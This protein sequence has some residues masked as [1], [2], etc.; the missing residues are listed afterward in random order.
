[1]IRAHHGWRHVFVTA[2]LT[3]AAALLV[4]ATTR[5]EADYELWLAR[6][7]F[8]SMPAVLAFVATGMAAAWRERNESLRACAAQVLPGLLYSAA[9]TALLFALLPPELRIQFDET[10]I[11]GASKSMHEHH[12]CVVTTGALP[13]EGE[14]FARENTT[15][16]RPPLFA[17]LV[18]LLHRVT[19]FRIE[20]GFWVNGILLTVG[21]TATFR[22]VAARAGRLCAFLAPACI[23]TVPAIA[24]SATS[25][26]FDLMASAWL[27]IALFAAITFLERPTNG[28]F[29]W[30]LAALM[31]LAQSRYES[32]LASG[33]IAAFVFVAVRKR[34]RPNRTGTAMLACTPA[35]LLPVILLLYHSRNPK[36]YPEADG[37]SLVGLSHV[38]DHLG[39]LLAALLSPSPTSPF[40]AWLSMAGAIA[41]ALRIRKSGMQAADWL[42]AGTVLG[43]TG[44]ALA[45][46]Y[47]DVREPNAVRLFLP[48]AWSTALLPLLVF[49]WLGRRAST[50]LAALIVAG[51]GI[52]IAGMARGTSVSPSHIT[53]LTNEL[54]T[55]TALL[56]GEPGTT[57][58][59]GTPAQHLILHGHA[60]LTPA[61]FDRRRADL[62]VLANRGDLQHV[63]IL[64]TAIDD[65]MRAAVGNMQAVFGG[66]AVER[67][68][69]H[70]TEASVEVFR[71]K[72]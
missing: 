21:M 55:L 71:M 45:W 5:A 32:L 13:V 61:G 18:H 23:A 65:E 63:Y 1:M 66:L 27:A 26:G 52:R 47:G 33:G 15:D 4:A 49:R 51:C 20:N 12:A 58:W 70:R 31:L 28:H 19:G 53:A 24:A 60:A 44:I 10:S 72:R 11:L 17:F 14:V 68:T 59:I 46:F 37:A 2:A 7:L 57:L 9:I 40:P 56:P 67:I 29:C 62:Q 54:D 3:A 43:S 48:L 16:K 64:R 50:V 39:P 8:W 38:V 35:L 25:A 41:L 36:F 42:V 22:F 69:P 6:L 34:Y 30:L